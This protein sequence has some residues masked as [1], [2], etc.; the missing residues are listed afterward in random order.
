M[1]Q[2]LIVK[3]ADS[4]RLFSTHHLLGPLLVL[5]LTVPTGLADSCDT[6]RTFADGKQPLREMFVSPAGSDSTGDGERGNPYRTIGRALQGAR[7]G[8]AIR[9]LPGTHVPGT[10]ISN[11]AG[12]SNAPIWLGGV[13]GLGR[14]RIESGNTALHLSRA[15]YVIV[16][17]IEVSGATANGINCDDGGDYAHTNATHHV[18]FRSLF[19][20]DIGTGGNQDGLKLSGV[21]DYAVL[22]CEFARMSAGGSGIDH[23]GCHRGLIASCIFTDAGSNAIQCKGGSADIEIRWNRFI[24]GGT[25]AINLGGS[26]GFEFFRPP[27]SVGAPNVEARRIRVIANL[28]QG[29][30]SPVAFVGAVD[31]LVANNTIVQPRRWLLRILQE[32]SSSGGYT[33]LP[34]GQNEFVNNLV[35]FDRWQIST[36]IN[37][38]PNTDAASFR[39]ANNLWYAFDRPELSRP[40]LPAQETDGVYGSD[41]LFKAAAAGDFS[42]STNSPAAG[43]GRRLPRV[44]ADLTERCYADPPT[45]GAFEAKPVPLGSADADR[46][47]MPD[48]WEA[49]HGLDRDN[50]TDAV[51]DPDS[52]RLTNLSEYIAGT[53]PNDPA[54]TF[55]LCSPR[56][57]TMQ[58]TFRSRSVLG[59][60]YR[61]ESVRLGDASGWA[62]TLVVA[63]TGEEIE[64]CAPAG[65]GVG[66]LFRARVVLGPQPGNLT[67][68][69]TTHRPAFR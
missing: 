21:Y 47:S 19:I 65:A 43:K 55:A 23:V 62:E 24:N 32:T 59:R 57:D 66:R 40:A 7:P 11:L 53:D 54:S 25:R 46:D 44:W 8:D 6:I 16:E 22:D 52:D 68:R 69:P 56:V 60:T 10:F 58:F 61:I 27:L 51:L 35:C 48:L 36:Y 31:S 41:P 15:S 20:H 39:F 33:F 42:L 5:A 26:T 64:F 67:D 28:F 37:I 4:T 63:G 13:P 12:T 34:C 3:C 17:H 29:G 9:L 30:D 50:P 1:K 49:E 45:I 14:P 18:L 38:G 2:N